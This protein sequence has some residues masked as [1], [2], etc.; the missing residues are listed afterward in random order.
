MHGALALLQAATRLD[1]RRF[2]SDMQGC[3]GG[4]RM[5]RRGQERRSLGE[6]YA[7]KGQETRKNREPAEPCV[8]TDAK[9][10]L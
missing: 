4:G 6:D 2:M 7:G 3:N 9:I 8:Q 10:C 5:E 1:S